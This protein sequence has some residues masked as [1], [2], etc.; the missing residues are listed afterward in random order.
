MPFG[1]QYWNA[2]CSQVASDHAQDQPSSSGFSTGA[3][4]RVWVS[5]GSEKFET[6][7]RESRVLLQSRPSPVSSSAA[8]GQSIELHHLKEDGCM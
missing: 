2:L 1:S 8:R 5:V 6:S 4:E 3:I 7:N